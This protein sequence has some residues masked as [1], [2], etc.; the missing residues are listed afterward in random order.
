MLKR[1]R[2][3]RVDAG[4]I[5]VDELLLGGADMSDMS[6]GALL[7]RATAATAVEPAAD[8]RCRRRTLPT[9]P[10]HAKGHEGGDARAKGNG[11]DDDAGEGRDG[12]AGKTMNIVR[13][14]R[15]RAR[16]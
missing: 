8:S 13:V 9:A 3:V 6:D 12:R 10:T 15:W 2:V 1:A 7:R 5:I 16:R 14:G 11:A 4:L